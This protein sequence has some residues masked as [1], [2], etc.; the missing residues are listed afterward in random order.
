MKTF[1]IKYVGETRVK[2]NLTDAVSGK[3]LPEST[4]TVAPPVKKLSYFDT[5]KDR[6]V[7][8]VAVFSKESGGYFSHG[9]PEPLANILNRSPNY[10]IVKGASDYE[11]LAIQVVEPFKVINKEYLPGEKKT[12]KKSFSEKLIEQGK[13]VAA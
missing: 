5:E 12:F 7:D 3:V 13:A 9:V 8:F 1:T 10:Q 4:I 11:T 6:K 2:A